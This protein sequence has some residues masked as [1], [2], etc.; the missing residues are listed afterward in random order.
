M[1]EIKNQYEDK[2]EPIIPHRTEEV[3]DIIERMPNTFA[4]YITYVVF[5]IVGLLIFFGYIVKYPDIVTGEVT[6]SA[7]QAPL[8][9]IAEQ[10]GKL[11]INQLKSQDNVVVGQ[12][13]AWIDNPA[14]PVLVKKISN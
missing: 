8:R 14:D 4:K 9:L 11:K 13:I 1:S 10:N 7:Q 12:L 2:K 5:G 6:I 3:R